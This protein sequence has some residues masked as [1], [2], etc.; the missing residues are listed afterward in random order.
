M[1]FTVTRQITRARE[2]SGVNES[3]LPV[4][5]G[6]NYSRI[7]IYE[8]GVIGA[9]ALGRADAVGIVTHVARSVFTSNVLVMLT[10]TF[11]VENTVAAV[12]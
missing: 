8:V 12:A 11:V 1:I 9:V 10:E 3:K 6:N 5:I 2:S 4:I 7:K